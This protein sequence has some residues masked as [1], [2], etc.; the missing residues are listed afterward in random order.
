MTWLKI[1]GEGGNVVL[2]CFLLLFYVTS[3]NHF[4]IRLW[5]R[6][7][8]DYIQLAMTSS[9]V[10]LRR[11][12]KALSKTK[13]APKK[14]HSH[15]LVVC[16]P[17][18]PLQLSEFLWNNYI[19]ELCSANQWAAL[20]SATPAT[21]IG[22]QNGPYSSAWRTQDHMSHNQHFKSWM[23][24]AAKFCLICHSSSIST[25]FC[26][27]RVQWIL[28]TDFYVTGINKLISHWQKCV[29]YNGSYFN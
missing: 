14:G 21:G 9:V 25:T 11:S 12:S 22:Q 10:G 29:N 23:N 18:D 19:W 6:Q 5:E 13:L 28:S 3:M 26:F 17:S 8:V 2:K 4:S 16:W 24:W 27:P 1:K 20:K 7:K 15:C